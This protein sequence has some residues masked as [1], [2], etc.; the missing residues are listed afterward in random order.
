MKYLYPLVLAAAA[1][2]AQTPFEFAVVKDL[3]QGS[4]HVSVISIEIQ[5]GT[6]EAGSSTLRIAARTGLVISPTLHTIY[7][8]TTGLFIGQTL[9]C[10]DVE[11]EPVERVLSV[12]SDECDAFPG[13]GITHLALDLVSY[14]D[15][16]WLSIQCSMRTAD[17]IAAGLLPFEYIWDRSEVS[18]LEI[19]TAGFVL[20]FTPPVS[21]TRPVL[22]AA[23]TASTRVSGSAG[24][25][26]KSLVLPGW[27]QLA[28]GEGTWW[29]NILV[30][31]GGVGLAL[32][33]HEREGVAVLGANHILSFFDLL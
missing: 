27:G 22:A 15:M 11:E 14:D 28:S 18:G 19:G 16:S 2:S 17:S 6:P 23:D 26:W 3:V 10:M 1:A 31:A 7:P 13:M 32:S 8:D 9:F 12:L 20:D 24:Q 29:I 4:P 25:A 21:V 5:R 30:E 33:G